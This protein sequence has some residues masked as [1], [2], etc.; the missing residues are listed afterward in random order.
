M[1]GFTS[2]GVVGFISCE[3]VGFISGGVVGFSSSGVIVVG[4]LRHLGGR[5]KRL[6][7]SFEATHGGCYLLPW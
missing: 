5:E 3:V 1:V 7:P 4:T 6:K 2:C